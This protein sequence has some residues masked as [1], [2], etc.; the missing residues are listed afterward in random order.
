MIFTKFQNPRNAGNL[1][2]KDCRKWVEIEAINPA[3]TVY[4]L[5][6]IFY[7]MRENFFC[8][9]TSYVFQIMLRGYMQRKKNTCIHTK[10]LYVS[11]AVR[12]LVEQDT[13]ECVSVVY[14]KLVFKKKIYVLCN[15]LMRTLK[16]LKK[17]LPINTK[18]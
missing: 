17:N 1:C 6:Y 9:T 12:Y 5:F 2:I 10:S 4:F 3:L 18:K 8:F 14:L 15:F 13:I 7:P 11:H 16:Y